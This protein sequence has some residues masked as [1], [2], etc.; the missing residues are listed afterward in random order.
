MG[1]LDALRGFADKSGGEWIRKHRHS[2]WVEIGNLALKKSYSQVSYSKESCYQLGNNAAV[3]ILRSAD[4]SKL[5]NF[6][7]SSLVE[8]DGE[9]VRIMRIREENMHDKFIDESIFTKEDCFNV[10]FHINPN[11]KSVATTI[12][13]LGETAGIANSDSWFFKM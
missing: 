4:F 7:F 10:P 5:R 3:C 1:L 8:L 9:F 6:Y 11:F 13:K 12:V 2:T